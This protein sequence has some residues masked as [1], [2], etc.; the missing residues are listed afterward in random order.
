AR[1]R[2]RDGETAGEAKKIE[3]AHASRQRGDDAAIVALIV[4]PAGLLSADR[5]GDETRTVFLDRDRY[6]EIAD[7]ALFRRQALE[8]ARRAV[9]AQHDGA[10][11]QHLL[12]RGKKLAFHSVNPGGV[13]FGDEHV[14]EPVDHDS[15]QTIRLGMDQAIE[16]A[17]VKPFAQSQRCVE[18]RG[19][20]FRVDDTARVAVEETRADQRT[21]IE[22]GDTQR[23]AR[24]GL[25]RHQRAGRQRFGRRVH[26]DFVGIDPGMALLRP[27]VMAG[28]QRHYRAS[29]GIVAHRIMKGRSCAPMQVGIE[30]RW[31]WTIA[32]TQADAP[33]LTILMPCL[34]EART[35][36][37]CVRKAQAFLAEQMYEGEII[38]A[39]NG[40]TDG[41]RDIAASLGAR[42]VA[43]PARGYGNALQAGIDAARGELVI[44]GDSDDS[45]DFRRLDG[46]VARL[47]D[48]FDLVVGNRFRGGIAKGAKAPLHGLRIAEVPTILSPDGR[49]RPPHL[50]S[51]RDGWRSLRF[52]L[53][54]SPR[55]LFLY[56]GLAMFTAAG[57]LSL[58]LI[59][60]DIRVGTVVFSFHTLIL[61]ATMTLIG[62][63]SVVF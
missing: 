39:D 23:L 7:D 12:T 8:R 18:A 44:M 24:R 35:L 19:E 22:H 47:A 45:Y 58:V 51:W 27:L 9:V 61:S 21:R 56:P 15:R 28:Q 31:N 63:Q 20:K 32:V 41:S 50:R 13:D 11:P 46:F 49:G 62:V 30:W 37:T 43:V 29:L 38:V 60:T 55:W 4:E 59:A 3:H 14:V 1:A 48:G 33:Y 16:W 6:A 53:L 10:R 57:L 26:G 5:V 40:S 54:L 17:V 36:E 42:V 34:N 52:Y 25:H 2:R